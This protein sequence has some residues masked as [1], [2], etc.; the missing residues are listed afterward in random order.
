MNFFAM[1][2]TRELVEEFQPDVM[3]VAYS[4]Q[5]LRDDSYEFQAADADQDV[6]A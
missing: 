6:S 1:D 3:V 5:M 4:M 2:G